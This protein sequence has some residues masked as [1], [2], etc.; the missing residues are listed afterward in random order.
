MTLPAG[1]HGGDGAAIARLL[2]R[3]VTDVIDLSMS[4]NP[5]APDVA[6][7][8]ADLAGVVVRYPEPSAA[9]A[10]LA[11]AIGVPA[12]R[13]VL[14]NG[15]AEA[16]AL[17]AAELGVGEIVDP[18]FSLYRR[19]LNAVRPGAG[20]WRS[21]PSNPLGCLA[22]AGDDAVV[23]DEAF[24]PLA[25]GTW[26]RGDDVA[27]RL[28]SLT[29]LWAC[30][31]LRLGYV[32]AP[33]AAQAVRVARRQP[34]WAVNALALAVVEPLLALTDLVRWTAAVA[35][36]R[37]EL[38]GA[39]EALGHDVVD[40]AAN[41]ILVRTSAPLRDELAM[42]G[43]V[44]RDSASFGLAGTFRVAVPRPDDMARVVAAFGA[45]AA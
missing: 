1:E 19:H 28:G 36:I 39:L 34:H 30:P 6:T 7:I 40:T 27:W 29:K 21:N 10:A 24:W 17:V 42:H 37:A 4:L 43:V 14:T 44:V 35:A 25:T 31:G 22:A 16:I 9:T 12:D 2:G 20:R 23:W 8:V 41:W 38:V 5:V 18:E 45:V 32:I 11:G 33:D 26:T 13:V 15:G 3:R